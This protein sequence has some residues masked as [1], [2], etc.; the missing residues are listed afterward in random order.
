MDRRTGAL[1]GRLFSRILYPI[2]TP[3]AIDPGHPF[4]YLAH[5][6]L[7]LTFSLHATIRRACPIRIFPWCISDAGR[8][9][10]YHTSHQ[11]EPTRLYA[12]GKRLAKVSFA[13]LSGLEILSCHAIRVT[14]D[15]DLLGA[16]EQSVRERRMGDAVRLQ[17]DSDL[18]AQSVAILVGEPELETE[19]LYPGTGFTAFTD[20]IQ[21]YSAIN[22][23]RLKDR[24]QLPVFVD[25]C[26]RATDLW[27]AIRGGDVLAFYP[28]QSF[29][30]VT[31]FVEEAS[32]DR[33]CWPSR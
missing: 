1:P 33:K 5:R 15:E 25:A 26:N 31:H 7:C 22:A 2:V 8:T 9:A 23:A 16:I 27:G 29:D 3:L 21:L 10:F 20:L 13:P 14:R 18:P 6:S 24:L 30:A 19:D 12:V 28:Y 4:P 11:G 17:Y 32:K